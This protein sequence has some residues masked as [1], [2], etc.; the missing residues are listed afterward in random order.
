MTTP[1]FH[2]ATQVVASPPGL[3][4]QRDDEGDGDSIIEELLEEARRE[5]AERATLVQ[6]INSIKLTR[7]KQYQALDLALNPNLT[8]MAG[9]N[10]SGKSSILHALAVWEFC[11]LATTMER[12]G[13]AGLH[14]NRVG[15]QGFGIGD[16]EFSPINIPSLKHL[17]TNLK[18]GRTNPGQDG[19]TLNIGVQ[20]TT[21]IGLKHL[22]FGLSLA[23]DRLFIRVDA[24]NLAAG[25]AIPRI[26]FLPP[27]AGISAHE[28]RVS[29]AVRRRRIGEGLA[30]AVLRNLLLD[31]QQENA[32]KRSVLRNSGTRGGQ[33]KIKD[34]DLDDLRQ[35]DPWEI[36]QQTLREVF[37]A[38]LA[39]SEFQEEY[40]SYI[41]VL[42]VKGT[43]SGH[44]LTPHKGFTKRDLM[45]EGSG[46]LQWLSV[47]AL[48]TSP[49]VDV[50]LLD[51]PDAHLHPQ[52]Q[53]ELVNRLEKLTKASNKQVFVATH[54]S[55]ILRSAYPERILEF[56]REDSPRY[57]TADH[58]KVGLLEGLGSHYAPRMDQMRRTRK[59]FFHEGTSDLAVLRAAAKVVGTQLSEDWIPWRTERSHKERKMLWMALKEEIPGLTAISLRDRDEEEVNTVGPELQDRGQTASPGFDMRKWRRRHIESYLVAPK[60]M[61][62]ASGKSESHIRE[63]L[64]EEHALAIN[65]SYFK[66]HCPDT[67]LE[68]RGKSIL[69]GLHLTA[70][71]VAGHLT[72]TEVCDDLKTMVTLLADSEQ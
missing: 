45:V 43:L 13:V 59:V 60:A 62:A 46:F 6:P 2:P 65:D 3:A 33:S 63:H 48:A 25:D 32:R 58:H 69:Q 11:R 47:F 34:K 22:T 14:P 12:G 54:S 38:E 36:L 9:S 51:E 19:Y 24:S 68:I 5:A 72:P 44:K 41:Q 27:F 4:L 39:V 28:Q 18:P 64:E 55:E 71:A 30:G 29:G 7:F 50:L 42:V 8:L 53:K 57:L 15:V 10:N 20:W 61:S 37:G 1:D 67:L 35:S 40:H 70:A 56:R 21:A 66:H 49:D 52:L 23:N 16:D 31:M 26:A 17:W